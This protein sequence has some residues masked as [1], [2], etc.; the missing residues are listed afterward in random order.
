VTEHDFGRGRALY[1]GVHLDGEGIAALVEHLARRAGLSSRPRQ[2]C[3][4]VEISTRRSDER[5]LVFLLNHAD[6]PRCVSIG[7]G[8]EDALTGE[9]MEGEVILPPRDLRILVRRARQP[10]AGSAYVD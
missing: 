8:G 9:R 2:D 1:V 6:Q 7:D 10:L 3:P 4:G 5:E